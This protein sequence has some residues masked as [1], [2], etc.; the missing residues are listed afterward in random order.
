MDGD[1]LGFDAHF[2]TDLVTG[3]LGEAVATK[4]PQLLDVELGQDGGGHH[5]E[6]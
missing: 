1:K 4:A 2:R 3:M 5:P 6:V